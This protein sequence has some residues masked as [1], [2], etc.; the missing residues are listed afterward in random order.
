M[1]FV[2]F[3]HSWMEPGQYYLKQAPILFL[4]KGSLL[5]ELPMSLGSKG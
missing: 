4:V 3:H 1:G 2:A 5:H